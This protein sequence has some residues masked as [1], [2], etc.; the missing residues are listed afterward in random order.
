METMSSILILGL[1][2]IPLMMFFPTAVQMMATL[3]GMST[4]LIG[5]PL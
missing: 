1:V 3:F 5:M 2:L 4:V